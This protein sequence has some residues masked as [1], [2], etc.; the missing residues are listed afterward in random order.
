MLPTEDCGFAVAPYPFRIEP[1][2]ELDP[3]KDFDVTVG[4]MF[5]L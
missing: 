5:G 3:F 2:E 4:V 1:L